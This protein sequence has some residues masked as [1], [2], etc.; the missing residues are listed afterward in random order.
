ML[1]PE[2]ELHIGDSLSQKPKYEKPPAVVFIQTRV[3]GRPSYLSKAIPIPRRGWRDRL[4]TPSPFL[5]QTHLD[6]LLALVA[7]LA[8]VL[9]DLALLAEALLPSHRAQLLDIGLSLGNLALAAHN[10]V[11][12]SV[13][14]HLGS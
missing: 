11:V 10:H 4:A 6:L 5:A 9:N 13:V 14:A 1:Q 3:E 7:D 12:G 8:L 2:L